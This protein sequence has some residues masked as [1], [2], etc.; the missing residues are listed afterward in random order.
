MTP[1]EYI[2]DLHAKIQFLVDNWPLP[3]S[4]GGLTFPDG[5]FWPKTAAP[6]IIKKHVDGPLLALGDGRMHWLTFAERIALALRLT[7]TARLAR[8]HKQTG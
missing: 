2:D 5:D 4:D 3:M 1:Q 7:D 6:Y 8:K